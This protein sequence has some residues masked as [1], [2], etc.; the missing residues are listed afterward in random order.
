MR[1]QQVVV[2]NVRFQLALNSFHLH[3]LARCQADA[4][5]LGKVVH[6]AP[7]T[8]LDVVKLLLLHYFQVG[9]GGICL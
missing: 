1:L 8:L 7:G 4:I 5:A 9:E 3:Y 6:I 2:H